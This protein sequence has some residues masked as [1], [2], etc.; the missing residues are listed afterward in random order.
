MRFTCICLRFWLKLGQSSLRELVPLWV[1]WGGAGTHSSPCCLLMRPTGF[2]IPIRSHQCCTLDGTTAKKSQ[3]HGFN[4]IYMEIQAKTELRSN[5]RSSLTKHLKSWIISQTEH[6]SPTL[7]IH[8]IDYQS[9]HFLSLSLSHTP[10]QLSGRPCLTQK[11]PFV[12]NVP[13]TS[14]KS[15]ARVWQS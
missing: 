5:H 15:Y 9:S 8:D 6:I 11:V 12:L 13:A 14:V 10:T 1:L 7:Q 4:H 3:R 2:L